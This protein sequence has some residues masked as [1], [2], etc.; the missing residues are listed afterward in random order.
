MAE[1]DFITISLID[2]K[3]KTASVQVFMP[4]G[5][6]LAE[7]DALSDDICTNLDAI[8]GATINGA[9]VSKQLTLP[10]G[11]K[12][13]AAANVDIEMGAN[14]GFD[15]A[16]TIYK[17][18]IRVP[19]ISPTKIVGDNVTLTDPIV[20]AFPDG[21]TAGVA[22]ALPSDRYGNDLVAILS[23]EVSFWKG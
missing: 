19:S 13:V 14:F 15:A 23:G 11:L 20:Q 7:I 9:A 10:A 22:G 21:I 2:H 5:L 17:H 12:G 16:D 4:T 8:V 1:V 18:T 6:T 3:G